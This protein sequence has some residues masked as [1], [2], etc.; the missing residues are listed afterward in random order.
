MIK[1]RIKAK[2]SLCLILIFSILL[3]PVFSSVKAED[4]SVFVEKDTSFDYASVMSEPLAYT[5]SGNV[6]A[7]LSG[8]DI[9]SIKLYA[10]GIPFGVK[11]LTEGV[12]VVGFADISS[13]GKKV[14]PS[15][16]AGLKAGDRIISVNGCEL[17]SAEDLTKRVEESHGSS[18]SIV[19]LRNDVRYTTTL[20][21]VFCQN[22]QCYKT[23]LYVKDNG[24]GIGTVTYVDPTT[25]SFGGLGHGICD[26]E[27]G[28]LIPIQRGSVLNVSIN[29]AI[30]G[31]KGTPG[32]VK[33]SFLSGKVGTLLKN[34][35]CGVY[36]VY[37]KLPQGLATGLL[38]LCP[39]DELKEGKAH[40]WC[41]LDA[42]GPQKYEIEI[43]NINRGSTEGR[44]FTV[45]VK[46]PALLEKTGGIVQGM[47]GSPIIQNG[48]LVGAVTHVLIN[49][50]TTGYGIFIENMLNAAQMPM[51]MAS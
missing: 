48:K 7:S 26:S 2:L 17:L 9:K 30:K 3:S 50:P 46:D 51:A 47:S 23:G 29:G 31:Q 4:V 49:D 38:S 27:S 40:I 18:L 21:P 35:D 15:Q 22:E 13:G 25:L 45:K 42:N 32:E 14:N 34:T 24:A 12:L 43:S 16:S 11:F 41:T 5:Q 8:S 44:S 39:K 1:N 36:G 20:T 19:Y 10:G 33:G 37:A 6:G 28:G